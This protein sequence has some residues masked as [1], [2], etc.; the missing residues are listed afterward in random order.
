MLLK[1][2]NAVVLATQTLKA[3]CHIVGIMV[4]IES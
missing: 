2:Y 1:C 4:L 3:A